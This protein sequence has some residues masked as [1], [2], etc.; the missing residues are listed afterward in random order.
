[1]AS[2]DIRNPM[3]GVSLILDNPNVRSISKKVLS[4]ELSDVQDGDVVAL[5]WSGDDDEYAPVFFSAPLKAG[6]NVRNFLKEVA[7]GLQKVVSDH[8]KVHTLIEKFYDNADR[9][10]LFDLFKSGTLRVID[11]VGPNQCAFFDTLERD[12]VTGVWSYEM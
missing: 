2:I 6:C 8:E 9:L 10:R 5:L 12:D 4:S 1:M 3:D 11:L 7:E